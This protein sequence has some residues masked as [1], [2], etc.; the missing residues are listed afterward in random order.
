[1]RR[2]PLLARV[3]MLIAFLASLIPASAL[4]DGGGFV[5]NPNQPIP[6]RNV[7]IEMQKTAAPGEMMTIKV[8]FANTQENDIPYMGVIKILPNSVRMLTTHPDHYYMFC[9]DKCAYFFRGDLKPY[10]A[11]VFT[12]EVKAPQSGTHQV[13]EADI[14]LPVYPGRFTEVA[15]L[16]VNT[17]RSAL[18]AIRSI[19]WSSNQMTI[20][21]DNLWMDGID[22]RQDLSVTLLREDGSVFRTFASTQEIAGYWNGGVVLRSAIV[23]FDLRG[24]VFVT[25]SRGKGNTIPLQPTE[26]KCPVNYISGTSWIGGDDNEWSPNGLEWWTFRRDPRWPTTNRTIFSPYIGELYEVRGT[27]RIRIPAGTFVPVPDNAEYHCGPA[28]PR[29]LAVIPPY[30]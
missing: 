29:A 16:S 4:A 19:V 1:M 13:V 20:Q 22:R 10:E 26:R 21:G 25:T 14:I 2:S 5:R 24:S 8:T 27:E 6:A 23:P 15:A 17:P 30:L 7:T 12:F 11:K 18:P 28:V 9:R 3:L